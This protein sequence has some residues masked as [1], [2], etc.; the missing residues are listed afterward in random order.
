MVELDK[1]DMDE[2]VAFHAQSADMISDENA[3]AKLRRQDKLLVALFLIFLLAM[4]GI[5]L[6]VAIPLVSLVL[7]L[8]GLN[9]A[10]FTRLE[11]WWYAGWQGLIWTLA[12]GVVALITA[13]LG[14]QRI[15]KNAALYVEA[16]CPKCQE[17]DLFR[18]SRSRRDRL[19]AAFGF[20]IRRYACRNCTWKG[21]RLAGLNPE[22]AA[23]LQHVAVE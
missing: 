11:T 19:L 6:L 10:F 21:T 9:L 17:H 18:V 8:L 2:F 7:D 22:V 16:G 20:P 3:A 1:T 12:L 15:L 4:A 5:A 23:E 13:V 14:R